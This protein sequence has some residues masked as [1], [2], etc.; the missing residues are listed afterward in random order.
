VAHTEDIDVRPA[1]GAAERAAAL[2]L[3][4][5]VFV[6]EQRIPSRLEADRHDAD[7]LHLVAVRHRQVIGTCRV[8]IDRRTAKLGRLAVRRDAR[9]LGAGAALVV[10]AEAQAQAAGAERIALHAQA[11]ATDLYS[12]RGFVALGVPFREAGIEHVRMEK[13]L[14]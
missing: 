14:A 11:H 2:E 12:R 10:A 9:R 4:Y 5:Q 13:P 8:V 3:R 6:H 1:R 7:A